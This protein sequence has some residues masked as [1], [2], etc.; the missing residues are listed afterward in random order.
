MATN[1]EYQ[2]FNRTMVELLKVPHSQIKAKLEAEKAAK[3]KKRK[4][5]TSASG[6]ASSGKG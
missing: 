2:N 4:S 6:P 1:Q 5:K 3:V